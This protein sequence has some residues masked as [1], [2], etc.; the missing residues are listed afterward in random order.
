MKYLVTIYAIHA[1]GFEVKV[2]E[3]TTDYTFLDTC[4]ETE[5]E[6]ECQIS[7]NKNDPYIEAYRY[8]VYDLNGECYTK[9]IEVN[10]DNEEWD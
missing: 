10:R 9:V 7:E 8:V 2:A 6:I 5:N 4:E 1:D 3:L